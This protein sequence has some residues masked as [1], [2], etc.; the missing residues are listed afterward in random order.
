MKFKLPDTISSPQDLAALILEV[1]TY[2]RWFSHESIKKQT[3]AKRKTDPPPVSPE[4]L[5]VV[6]E[7]EAKQPLSRDRLDALIRTLTEYKKSA[8]TLTVTLA[9][10]PTRPVKTELVAWCRKNIAPDTL[11]T[12]QFNSSLLGGMVVRSGS[13]VFDWSFRR[14]ILE[15]RQKFPEILRNV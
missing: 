10:L 7:W 1:Q 2:A 14:Q 8:P 9:A 13:H 12:F 3:G 4:T 5:E 11:V 15:N 6:H